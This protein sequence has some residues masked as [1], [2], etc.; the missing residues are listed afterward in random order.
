MEFNHP[1]ANGPFFELIRTIET[2]LTLASDVIEPI[3]I[4]LFQDIADPTH[5]RC[6][7]WERES[8]R[9]TPSFP[10]DKDGQPLEISDDEVLVERSTQMMGDYESIEEPNA[11]AALSKVL[12]DLEGRLEHWTGK[13]A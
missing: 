8:F 12:K 4:E 6:R 2:E 13:K 5:F 7:L 3:R 9:L 11:D 1:A 10:Q